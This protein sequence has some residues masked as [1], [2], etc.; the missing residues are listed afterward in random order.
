MKP[1]EVQIY[2][3]IL[4]QCIIVSGCNRHEPV[5]SIT[6]TP[7]GM[8]AIQPIASYY[9]GTHVA[10]PSGIVYNAKSNSL[11]VVSDSHPELYEID[12]QGKLLRTITTVSTDLEGLALSKT[13]DTIYIVEEKNRKVVSYRTNGTKISSFSADVATLPNNALEGITVGKNGNLFVLNEKSPGMILEYQPNGTEINR[14]TLS[15]A[16]D[17]SDI[18]FDDSA[19]CLWVI[20]DESKKIM[21]INR[22]GELISQWL[23]PF[24]KG[25]GISIV[26]D[27]MYIVNDED[28]K[29]YIFNKPK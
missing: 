14:V 27:T 23:I 7:S 28:A 29:L 26:R 21:K 17:Y 25:E 20:S 15:H 5:S 1:T 19:D 24:F 22:N 6:Q 9:I 11:M 8:S 2:F 10:E 3:F 16:L 12:F 4:L 18:F 13:A